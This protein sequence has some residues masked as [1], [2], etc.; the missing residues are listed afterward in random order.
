METPLLLVVRHGPAEPAGAGGDAA[1][2]L[3]SE[4]RARMK[5]AATALAR[6]VPKP[7]AI[8]SSPLVRARET[9]AILADAFA[10]EAPRATALLAPG[11]DCFRL[12]AELGEAGA[13]PFALIAHAPD[14]ATFSEWLIGAAGEGGVKFAS[15]TAAVLTLAAPGAGIL[16]ALYPLD[17]FAFSPRLAERE[18]GS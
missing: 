12:A 18:R 4:G 5:G 10:V 16:R 13:G 7:Q 15:G 1:R 9:A 17:T 6:I 3:T 8:W 14:V 2:K 11:F